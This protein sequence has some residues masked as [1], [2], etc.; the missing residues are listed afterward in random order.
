MLA[1]VVAVTLLAAPSA[2]PSAA[3]ADPGG[4][5]SLRWGMSQKEALE[6]LRALKGPVVGELKK[7]S[8]SYGRRVILEASFEENIGALT[9]TIELAFFDG[10]LFGI[11]LMLRPM[12]G[13]QHERLKSALIAK[14]GSP[15]WESPLID[16]DT[17][18]RVG[19]TGIL[20]HVSPEPYLCYGDVAVSSESFNETLEEAGL[21]QAPIPPSKI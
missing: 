16:G 6:R 21:G 4:W 1:L 19:G 14:Y 20:L 15:E 9:D 11:T 12:A 17:R 7:K 3:P 10:K 18:W 8:N 2:A 13:N 5:R